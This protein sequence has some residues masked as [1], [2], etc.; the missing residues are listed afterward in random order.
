MFSW[1]R[2][3]KN[4]PLCKLAKTKIFFKN[5]M[6]LKFDKKRQT[7]CAIKELG[8]SLGEKKMNIWNNLKIIVNISYR[9]GSKYFSHCTDTSQ[10]IMTTILKKRGVG[11]S[12]IIWSLRLSYKNWREGGDYFSFSRTVFHLL[13]K[14]LKKTWRVKQSLLFMVKAKYIPQTS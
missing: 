6:D 13:L 11:E 12:N 8:F 1:E 4:I 3:Y 2:S 9:H 10:I 5:Y 7:V 14:Q